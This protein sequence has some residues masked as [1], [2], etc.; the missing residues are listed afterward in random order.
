MR[1]W[2]FVDDWNRLMWRAPFRHHKRCNL[3]IEHYIKQRQ[4]I[5]RCRTKFKISL[6]YHKR[7]FHPSVVAQPPNFHLPLAITP[8][9]PASYFGGPH[10]VD[11]FRASSPKTRQAWWREERGTRERASAR[12]YPGVI[13][14]HSF[15][16]NGRKPNLRPSHGHRA[17]ELISD[18]VS[19]IGIELYLAKSQRQVLETIARKYQTDMKKGWHPNNDL[20]GMDRGCSLCLLENL[21]LAGERKRK[22]VG[23]LG[24][25]YIF[26]SAGRWQR[27]KLFSRSPSV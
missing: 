22:S 15:C 10:H 27:Q 11:A 24:G 18:A 14:T 12:R 6:Y 21:L 13:R 9:T 23:V 4:I 3:Q 8:I 16:Q 25:V 1:M 26:L 2:R 7:N 17:A 20:R 19:D 5:K